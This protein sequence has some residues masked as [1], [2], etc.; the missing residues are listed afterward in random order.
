MVKNSPAN[1][2][3]KRCR[4]G[5]WVRKIPWRRA[6][7][8][9]PV[10]LPG[11]SHG[12]RSLAGYNPWDCKELDMNEVTWHTAPFILNMS[13]LRLRD[14]SA[15]RSILRS[16]LWVTQNWLHPCASLL[17]CPPSCC[18]VWRTLHISSGLT[19]MLSWLTES[20]REE[21]SGCPYGHPIWSTPLLYR[22][23]NHRGFWVQ[24]FEQAVWEAT[25]NARWGSRAWSSQEQC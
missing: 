18:S 10:S 5:P 23:W 4:F 15:H 8:P 14:G 21:E 16:L 25:E 22:F 20:T 3:D 7:Q 1:A 6:W 12:Q 24:A 17:V 9:T 2:G 13:Q 11:E 19:I